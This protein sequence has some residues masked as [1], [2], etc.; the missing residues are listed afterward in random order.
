MLLDR[1]ADTMMAIFTSVRA[2]HRNPV[3]LY[4]WAALVVLVIGLSLLA[5]FFPLLITAPI[6]GHASWHAYRELV[7]HKATT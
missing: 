3:A 2:V 1:R 4:F 7:Q 6:V 5:G